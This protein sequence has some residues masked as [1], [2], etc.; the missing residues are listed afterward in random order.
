MTSGKRVQAHVGFA[1]VCAVKNLF[2]R[3]LT[4]SGPVHFILDGFEEKD[5]GFCP[6]VIIHAGGVNVQDFAPEHFFRRANIA[7]AIHQL[8]KIVAAASLFQKLI[9]HGKSLDE[10]FF[11]HRIGPNSELSTAQ[12]LHAIAHRDDDI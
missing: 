10:V 7:D 4:V 2:C 8:I 6:R 12:R 9:I 1:A 5:G 11:Q 3:C